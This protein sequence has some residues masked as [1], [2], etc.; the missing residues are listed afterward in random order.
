V[1]IRPARADCAA[2]GGIG[3][4]AAGG[5]RIRLLGRDYTATQPE[6]LTMPEAGPLLP[7]AFSRMERASFR[8]LGIK[9]VVRL[10]IERPGPA[11]A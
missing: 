9:Q 5:C 1:L 7:I 3:D 6:F 2:P 11:P 10:Q 8:I 4:L